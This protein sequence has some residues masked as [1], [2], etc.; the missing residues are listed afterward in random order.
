MTELNKNHSEFL[1]IGAGP[2]GLYTAFRFGLKNIS[3]TVIEATDTVGG[4]CSALYPEKYLYD[5][6]GI[7]EIKVSDFINNLYTQFK[8]YPHNLVLGTTVKNIKN[9]ENMFEIETNKETYTA[10]NIILTTGGGAF[11]PMKPLLENIDDFP[12]QILYSVKSKELLRNK[13]IAIFGG[14]DSAV[15]W[16]INL[17]GIASNITLVHRKD[18]FRALESNVKKLEKLKSENKLTIYTNANLKKIDGENGKINNILISGPNNEDVSLKIDYILIFFGMKME[19]TISKFDVGITTERGKVQVAD[20]FAKSSITNIYAIG[21]ASIF[22]DKKF[23]LTNGF[24]QAVQL[25]EE[26]SKK[27]Q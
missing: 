24:G 11:T 1:I 6:P 4:Q 25:V 10:N 18:K 8:S 2:I 3:T 22:K 7:P 5:I 26:L 21:D 23:N 20:N 27:N 15:D 14:G 13:N 16:A 19:D 12:N 17:Q 9:K